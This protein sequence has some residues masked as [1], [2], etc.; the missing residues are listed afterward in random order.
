MVPVITDHNDKNMPQ[1]AKFPVREQ[2]GQGQSP[3]ASGPVRPA[4]QTSSQ[5]IAES[6]DPRTILSSVAQQEVDIKKLSQ[7][8]KSLQDRMFAL[9]RRDL[10]ASSKDSLRMEQDMFI[11]NFEA[12]LGALKE[13]RSAG[14]TMEELRSENELLKR[15][16]HAI[17]APNGS[18][19]DED[20]S[21]IAAGTAVKLPSTAPSIP[22]KKKRQY[23]RRKPLGTQKPVMPAAPDMVDPD[24]RSATNFNQ[25]D[26]SQLGGLQALEQISSAMAQA[27]STNQLQMSNGDVSQ[28]FDAHPIEVAG[29]GLSNINHALSTGSEP[30]MR[31]QQ[32]RRKIHPVAV[33]DSG[34]AG[35]YSTKDATAAFT[36]APT[37]SHPDGF[38]VESR[39]TGGTTTM[40]STELH[41][42]IVTPIQNAA[43]SCGI[44]SAD[45]TVIDPAL[46]ST[47]VPPTQ[48]LP[49]PD[50][51][52]SIE[53]PPDG[54]QPRQFTPQ[55]KSDGVQQYD[56]IHEARIREYK[57]R[58]A[59][60]KR[61]ARAIS[62][63]KKKM[64]VEGIFKHEEKIRARDKM[65]K[66][67]MERE[68]ML[69]NED[70]F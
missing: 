68:E 40:Q 64:S 66:E 63:E 34:K 8:L 6:H 65:V 36:S 43:I 48:S 19:A 51:L 26:A 35:Q 15:R 33:G 37:G 9:E 30:C 44:L 61:K 53:N 50:V 20:S 18:D 32:K 7:S 45:E 12:M 2:D 39:V 58:D 11:D 28:D 31:Q 10:R 59:L 1:N 38:Q 21:S 52:S 5:T 54:R 17:T 24:S 23:V 67:L 25:D 16:L 70:D 41:Q 46:R 57:A 42:K 55:G 14:R 60:R 13:T 62:T 4:S 22:V 27:S 3:L 56:S 29:N 47:S 49:V 69:E